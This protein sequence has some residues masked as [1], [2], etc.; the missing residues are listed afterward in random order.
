MALIQPSKHAP[1]P[2]IWWKL[3]TFSGV[4]LLVFAILSL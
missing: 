4:V 1:R 2:D 3:I